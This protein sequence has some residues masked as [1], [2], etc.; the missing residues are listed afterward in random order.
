MLRGL[1]A[2]A[3]TGMLRE[4]AFAPAVEAALTGGARLV[5]Y[6]DKGTDQERRARQAAQVV[7]A[8][9]RH[10]ALAIINDDVDLACRVDADGVHIGREDSDA[11]TS[12]QRL[13]NHRILGVS[14]YNEL[15]R[16]HSARAGGADYVAFGSVYPSAT[17]P[18]AV[19]APLALL[20]RAARETGLAV[21]AIG[22]VT[23]E[24][25][26]ELVAA[27]ADMVAVIGDLFASESIEARA[28]D[29]ARVF[30][31]LGQE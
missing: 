26:P 30:E 14:C 3:D 15:A 25:A 8:C 2:I 12:R 10:D 31:Q 20:R 24:R 28:R 23:A 13:G 18:D 7:A 29:Y 4:P 16:A 19:R 22:G 21:C 1:Y 9:R 6:R 27:G 5:Q 11:A 17:K